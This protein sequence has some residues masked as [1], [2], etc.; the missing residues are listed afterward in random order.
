[1]EKPANL[2]IKAGRAIRYKAKPAEYKAPATQ[3]PGRRKQIP[4]EETS[5]EPIMAGQLK[6]N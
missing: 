1:M 4:S 3:S 6:K 5:N 2:K